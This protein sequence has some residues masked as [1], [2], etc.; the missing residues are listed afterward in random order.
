M[1]ATLLLLW[2]RGLVPELSGL[3]P[4]EDVAVIAVLRSLAYDALKGSLASFALVAA[5]GAKS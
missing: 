3:L 5:F 4:A 1:L 2:S